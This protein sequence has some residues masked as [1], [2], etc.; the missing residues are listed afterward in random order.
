MIIKRD[1]EQYLKILAQ[2]FPVVA[3]MGPRQSGKTTLVKHVFTEYMY[4]SME[5]LDIRSAALEDPRGFFAAY[6]HHKGLIIDEIQEVPS[7]FSYLQS[8]VDKEYKPG[9]FIITGSQHFLLYEK[10]TQTLAGR[11]A[12]LTLL[13]LSVHELQKA[14][15]LPEALNTVLFNGFYP[16]PYVQPIPVTTW[17]TQYINTYVE[18]DVRQVLA[19][20]DVVGFGKFLKLCA[21]RVGTMLNYASLAR[22][23]DISPNTAKAWISVLEASYIIKL[24]YPYYKNFNK[25]L[26]KSPK[27]YFYDTGLVCSLLGIKNS[28]ELYMHPLRG[29]LFETMVMGEVFKYYYNR[30]ESPAIYFWRDVSGDEID[31]VIEQSL[32]KVVPIE[33][34]A[35][36]TINDNFFKELLRWQN[37]VHDE[38][39]KDQGIKFQAGQQA[40]IYGGDQT[41]QRKQ[42]MV[43]AWFGITDFL[44]QL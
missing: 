11:I 12:L 38:S 31:L 9:F 13:P 7:L 3:V 8:I 22:D 4:V 30:T 24:V 10:I 1:I 35:G 14:H 32:F 23:A 2:Q 41:V 39:L 27:I 15:T 34:K 26:V 36:M 28:Q 21:A 44:Q 33:I 17:C 20:G 37:I 25:R 6:A 16:R 42:G 29:A 18:K 5:D 40:I 19:I 43:I